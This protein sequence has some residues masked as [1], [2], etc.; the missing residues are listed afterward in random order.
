MFGV[1]EIL[2]EAQSG[3]LWIHQPKKPIVNRVKI[4]Y[5][6]KENIFVKKR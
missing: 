1:P 4:G 2:R 6:T 3:P 5:F